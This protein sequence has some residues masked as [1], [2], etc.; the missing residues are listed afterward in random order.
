MPI[1]SSRDD[2]SSVA[3]ST[4][5]NLNTCSTLDDKTFYENQIRKDEIDILIDLAGHTERNR[6]GVIHF[7]TS[8]TQIARLGLKPARLE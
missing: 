1:K 5:S 6:L 3:P 2:V 8:R 7:E 4:L